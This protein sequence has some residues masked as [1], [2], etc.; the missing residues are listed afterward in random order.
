[1]RSAGITSTSRDQQRAGTPTL[2]RF[3]YVLR[4]AVALRWLD[5]HPD[6]PLPPMDLPTLLAEASM[7]A[8]LRDAASELIAT[9]AVTREL[10][11]GKPPTILDQF[12]TDQ[13]DAAEHFE[14][15]APE[16]EPKTVRQLADDFFQSAIA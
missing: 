5:A 2:K 14:T 6:Q 7:P 10:G 1:M 8:D 16:L 11:T 13:L 4:P 12:V 9:K 15:M 3:F